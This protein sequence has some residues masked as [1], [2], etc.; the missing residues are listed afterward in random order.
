MYA[1]S[2]SIPGARLAAKAE[3]CIQRLKY[4]LKYK[5][6]YRRRTQSQSGYRISPGC[7][8]GIWINWIGEGTGIVSMP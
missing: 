2:F 8:S 4:R 1:S 6:T 7:G 5:N 3:Y